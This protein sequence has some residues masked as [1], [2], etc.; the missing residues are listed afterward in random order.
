LPVEV[1]LIVDCGKKRRGGEKRHYFPWEEL[2]R[3]SASDVNAPAPRANP[4]CIARE[5][6]RAMEERGE[7]RTD[8]A[9]RLGLSRARVT[10]VLQVLDVDPAALELLEQNPGPSV[11]SERALRSLRGL[12]PEAQCEHVAK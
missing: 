6:K 4:I 12:S 10:Q 2:P 7:S 9:R 1:T 5:W 11:V 8:L 3:R